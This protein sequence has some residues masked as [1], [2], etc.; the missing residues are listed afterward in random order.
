MNS[1]FNISQEEF[2]LIERFINKQMPAEEYEAFSKKI[3]VDN[4]L[5]DRVDAIKLLLLGVEEAALEEKLNTFHESLNEGKPIVLSAGKVGSIR[6]WL[7]IAAAVLI[8]AI[9]VW[10]VTRN[11]NRE[12]RF[13]SAYYKPD[14]GLISA[15]STT[16]NYSFGRA[17]IDYKTG[18]YDAA[19]KAWENLLIS[20]PAN[21]TLNYFIGSAYL[22]ENKTN[23]A[24]EYLTKVINA[25]NGYFLKDAYWYMGL[26][27]LKENKRE[28]AISYIERSE[29]SQK[30]KLLQKLKE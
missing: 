27:L 28:Q 10:L 30:E 14:P 17:M 9:G 19:I 7:T 8:T 12:E 15:M 26:A 4:E 18:N 16:E 21:D 5:R 24:I 29:H 22:A 11:Y 1:N 25:G 2:E 20:K 6:S 23:K 3:V 13:F